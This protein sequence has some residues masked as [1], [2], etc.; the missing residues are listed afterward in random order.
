MVI[1]IYYLPLL[2]WYVI[3]WCVY[4][5]YV[6]YRGMLITFTASSLGKKV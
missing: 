3:F 4:L 5:A 6:Q 1:S 2:F